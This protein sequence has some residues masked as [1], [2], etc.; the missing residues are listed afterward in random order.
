[1]VA[2]LLPASTAGLL[3]D[4][5]NSDVGL[6]LWEMTQQY[7]LGTHHWGFTVLCKRLSWY[8]F[9]HLSVGFRQQVRD[10]ALE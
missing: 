8:N 5:K 4:S 2:L 3:N 6:T 9:P 10:A 7:I 1:M